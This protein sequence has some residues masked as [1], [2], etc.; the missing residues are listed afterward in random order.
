MI[1]D[2]QRDPPQ[3]GPSN[4]HHH[5]GNGVTL[6][7]TAA[8]A[9]ATKVELTLTT[10]LTASATNLTV[11]L[12]ADAVDDAAGNGNLV[13]A[14][15][16]VTNAIAA[17]PPG[18]PAAPSVSSVANS[19]T[20]LLVTWTAPANT[21]PAIDTYDLQYR[22]GTG[23]AWTNGPQDVSSTSA[24]ITGLT[25]NTLYQV[26]VLATNADGNSPW[27]PSGSGQTN[28]AGN[29]APTFANPTETRSVAENSPASTDVGL[30]VTATDTDS[31]DTLTYTLEGTD[32]AAF[33][34]VT[35]S[36]SAQIRT[37][38]GV[39]YD[40]EAQPS[41]TVIVKAD[42]NNDNCGQTR[43]PTCAGTRCALDVAR[44]R[45]GAEQ[46]AAYRARRIGDQRSLHAR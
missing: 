36:G 29:S 39:T 4:Q 3:H 44:H 14:A 37:R 7:T 42:D 45:G 22:Q 30:P 38:S 33:N 1:L 35:I 11:A 12:A 46:G 34:L 43:T 40:Y 31:G 9:A 15:T 19:T 20:S 16:A 26:Q 23:G 2:V 17:T 5:P 18:R 8:S 10:A 32:A 6:S 13:V 25:A 24:T 41:Y 27:S 28:T 21:G